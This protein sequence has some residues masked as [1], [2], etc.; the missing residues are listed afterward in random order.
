MGS[1]RDS[2]VSFQEMECRS[3]SCGGAVGH[4][5]GDAA[6]YLARVAVNG[7]ISCRDCAYVGGVAGRTFAG[8]VYDTSYRGELNLFSPWSAG[9]FGGAFGYTLNTEIKRGVAFARIH[10]GNSPPAL[11]GGYAGD[12]QNT[13]TYRLFFDRGRAQIYTSVI[14]TPLTS[15]Q[16]VSQSS[17][18]NFDFENIWMHSPS[19]YPLLRVEN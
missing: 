11:V 8:K 14:G 13:T 15:A 5:G 6:S 4:F 16:A 3:G 7:P 9:A 18:P 10:L 2:V 17:Y 12:A 1:I 19:T